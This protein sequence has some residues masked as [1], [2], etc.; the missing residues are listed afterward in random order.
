[1]KFF[2]P[3]AKDDAEAEAVYDSIRKA[4]KSGIGWDSTHS[5]I[6]SISYVVDGREYMSTVGEEDPRVHELV[7]AILESTTYLVCTPTRGVLRGDPI[8]VGSD[9]VHGCVKFTSV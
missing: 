7:I 8:L 5:R 3:G 1:M 2:L 4:A 6:Y 9:V